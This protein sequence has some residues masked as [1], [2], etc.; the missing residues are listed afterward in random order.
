MVGLAFWKKNVLKR[1]D[2]AHSI[3]QQ[4]SICR[5]CFDVTL[6]AHTKIGKGKYPSLLIITILGNV[7]NSRLEI[8][9]VT[10]CTNSWTDFRISDFY[11]FQKCYVV[12]NFEFLETFSFTRVK[13][14]L[15]SNVD[16]YYDH[17]Y[18]FVG[19]KKRFREWVKLPSV[20][21]EILG[22]EAIGC[23]TFPS[24]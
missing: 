9:E 24:T 23:Y 13:Q 14:K 8:F 4:F 2:K 17:I 12:S 11:D 16:K 7:M 10:S 3:S 1:W 19:N 18:A 6:N 15:Y 20:D 21:L 22:V 5:D